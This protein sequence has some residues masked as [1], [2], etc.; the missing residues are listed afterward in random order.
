MRRPTSL[1]V[2]EV[3]AYRRIFA[4]QVV[5]S[6]GDGFT[7]L[8]LPFAITD[9]HGSATGIGVVLAAR[10]IPQVVFTLLGGAVGDRI[11]PGRLLAAMDVVRGLVQ[12]AAG[13][14][15]VTGHA[16]LWQV[17]V[18]MAVYGLGSAF[19]FPASRA[20]L[21]AVVPADR[22]QA[23][24]SLSAMAFTGAGIG[25]PLL[26]GA[27]LAVA[28][29]GNALLV[30]ACSFAFSA[31]MVYPLRTAVQTRARSDSM[32]TMLRG[33]WNEIRAR[34]WLSVGLA[35]AAAFQ[36][37]VLGPLMVLGPVV[38][39]RRYHGSGG[40]AAFLFASAVGGL[41]SGLVALRHTV[42]RP[43]AGAYG[44]IL[45]A[46]A[47]PLALAGGAPFA[48]VMVA[49]ALYGAALTYADVLWHTTIQRS[50]PQAAQARVAAYDITVSMALRPAGLAAAG[51][52]TLLFG[53]RTV[54]GL[55]AAVLIVLTFGMFVIRDVRAVGGPATA[56]A[57]LRPDSPVE[58]AS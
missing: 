54:L 18:L 12:A 38:A 28:S 41:L 35:H 50:V 8:A 34:R 52:M 25:G 7:L 49:M 16:V 44:A 48:V 42:K 13:L 58:A 37:L 1:G 20:L 4:G 17:S 15:F 29:P 40:W 31:A 27:L 26:A 39:L 47:P 5:S 33:G 45:L 10:T 51:P 24:N 55:C 3:P 19:Y 14:L 56:A 53:P 23:A 32:T 36:L 6:L 43:L 9:A 11:A 57:G 2:L 30:D 21:P 22:L 46:V